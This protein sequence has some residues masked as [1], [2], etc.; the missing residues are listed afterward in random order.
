MSYILLD[1]NGA[2]LTSKN[3]ITRINLYI[4]EHGL[5]PAPGHFLILRRYYIGLEASEMKITAETTLDDLRK[6]DEDC[7]MEKEFISELYGGD[8]LKD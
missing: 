6:F 4:H 3:Y 8:S 7:L 5:K 2:F 1:E